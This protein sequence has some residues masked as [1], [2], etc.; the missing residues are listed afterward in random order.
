MTIEDLLNAGAFTAWLEKLDRVSCNVGRH[1]PDSVW[2]TS[3]LVL[4]DQ[5]Y[6]NIE[7]VTILK[8][9]MLRQKLPTRNSCR[10][11]H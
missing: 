10:G 8:V 4:L 7:L 5:R 9:L 11:L 3:F 2:A 1:W 6:E